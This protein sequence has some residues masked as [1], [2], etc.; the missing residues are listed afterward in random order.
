[1]D[2]KGQ[3]FVDSSRGIVMKLYSKDFAIKKSQLYP[4]FIQ[5]I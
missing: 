2:K 4:Q 1:M 5:H 3:K